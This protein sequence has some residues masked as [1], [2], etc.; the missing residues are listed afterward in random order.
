MLSCA[1][2]TSRPAVRRLAA[3]A[4]ALTALALGSLAAAGPALADITRCV[5]A[6]GTDG[7]Y[8]CYT[9]PRFDHIGLGRETIATIPVVC[10]GVGCT[11]PTFAVFVPSDKVDGRFTAVEYAGNTYT[12]Y[13]PTGAQPYVL[14]SNAGTFTPAEQA[15]V[16]VLAALLDA[17]N[18]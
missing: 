1:H 10:Y 11:S 13:R 14:T 17:A 16:L 3:T 6:V 2:T 4:T 15:Q 12:V 9:S 7:A 8:A 18:A 5:G